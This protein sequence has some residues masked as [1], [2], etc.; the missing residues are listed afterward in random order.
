MKRLQVRRLHLRG[1]SLVALAATTLFVGSAAAQVT[2]LRGA[3]LIDGNGAA[4][5]SNVTIVIDN[6]RL[7]DIGRDVATPPGAT[8]VDVT[9]KFVVPGI[10]N[11]H[12]HVGPAPRDPQ[13]RRYA[14]YGVTTT[15]SMAADPDDIVEFKAKQK[16]GDL[17]G[18]RILTVKYRFTTLPGNGNDYKT[19]EAARQH[20]DEIA[21]NGADFIKVWL[22][23]QGGRIPKLS[24]EYVAA[25]LDQA[26]KHGKLTMAHIVELA[27][28]RMAV[29]EGVNILVHNVRDQDIPAD[30]LATLKARNVSV[31]STLAREEGMFRAAGGTP[32]DPFFTKGLT[33][34]QRNNLAKKLEALAKDPERDASMRAFEQDKVNVKRLWDAG[35]RFGFGTDSGGASERYFVQGFYEHRQM[36]LLLQAG[37]TPMQ[38]IQS[39]SK[40]NSEM[41]GIDK[42]FGTLAKGK[43]ADLLVLT[44]NPLDDIANM[45]TFEAVYLGGK[46]FE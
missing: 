11:A 40:N 41:L 37:L 26:R 21:K 8:V 2:V 25:V 12:G 34:E 32:D 15:T 5:Q 18:A 39:F 38:V 22:D 33:P 45:R 10:I 17:R 44:K 20:V 4:P 31:I 7:R 43:A 42:D 28:A 35:I 13:L 16:A 46:K 29:D 6:G 24:R 1:V 30:F 23:A 36:D 14:L 9:G 27:D 3:T 19:P